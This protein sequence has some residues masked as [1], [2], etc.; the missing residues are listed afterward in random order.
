VEGLAA[1]VGEFP[2]GVAAERPEVEVADIPRPEAAGRRAAAVADIRQPVAAVPAR[3]PRMAAGRRR[4]RA[5]TQLFRQPQSPGSCP[6]SS[7]PPQNENQ[8]AVLQISK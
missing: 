5:A 3:A 2:P 8:R 1:A 7:K 6:S 4:P